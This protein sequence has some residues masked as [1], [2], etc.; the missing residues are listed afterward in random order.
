MT[1]PDFRVTLLG[2]G[3]I[4]CATSLGQTWGGTG[5]PAWQNA[6]VSLYAPGVSNT[7]A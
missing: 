2:T 7:G 3:P 4:Q 1:G 6:H 5:A